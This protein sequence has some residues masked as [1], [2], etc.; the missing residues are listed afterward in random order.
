MLM[1]IHAVEWKL[2]YFVLV[3][4]IVEAEEGMF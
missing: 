1:L 4:K 3:I 2:P